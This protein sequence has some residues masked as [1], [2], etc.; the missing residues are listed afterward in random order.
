MDILYKIIAPNIRHKSLFLDRHDGLE[1]GCGAI[2]LSNFICTSTQVL[3]SSSNREISYIYKNY[4]NYIQSYS[5]FK[6][7]KNL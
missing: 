2:L 3:T 7:I 4:G 6:I 1:T 5:K